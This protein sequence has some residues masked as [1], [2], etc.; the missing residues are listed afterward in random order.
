MAIIIWHKIYPDYSERMRV[1]SLPENVYSA[2]KRAESL[3]LVS[4]DRRI[5]C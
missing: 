3:S 2:I 1:M 4:I 5:P